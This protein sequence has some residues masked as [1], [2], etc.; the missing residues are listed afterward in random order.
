MK[1][2]IVI[3]ALLVAFA[4]GI[5]AFTLVYD[6]AVFD[7]SRTAN[8]DSCRLDI[9]RMTGSDQHT[10]E[11]NAG[12]TLQVQFETQSGSLHMKINAADGTLLYAG[13][14][15]DAT[16]FALNIREGGAYT[17]AIEARRAKG[18]I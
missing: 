3:L 16:S 14:G 7:G 17:V 9:A 2:K 1:Q 13:S 11:V 4:A 12:D 6:R 5:A 15:K 10:L 8:S 18:S